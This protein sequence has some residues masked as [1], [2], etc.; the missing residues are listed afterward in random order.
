MLFTVCSKTKKVK[1][2][3]CEPFVD[4]LNKKAIITATRNQLLP[5]LISTREK[6]FKAGQIKYNPF[7]TL[8]Y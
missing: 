8:N 4:V 3:I 6:T 2:V 1:E 7:K 5:N